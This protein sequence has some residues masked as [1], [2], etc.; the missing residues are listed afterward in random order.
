MKTQMQTGPLWAWMLTLL[1]AGL[2]ADAAVE[3]YKTE[4]EYLNRLAELG[5]GTLSEGFESSAWDI[6]RSP[7]INDHNSPHSVVSQSITWT[8]AAKDIWGTAYS[9]YTHGMT[10]NHNWARSGLWGLFEDHGG[11]GYPTVYRISS[12]IPIYAVGGWFDTN[13][14]YQSVGFL[15]ENRTTANDPGYVL[16]GYGAMYPA[17]VPAIGGHAFVGVVDPAGFTS[18]IVTTTLQVNEEGVLEGGNFVFGS[19]DFTIGVIPEPATMAML[20]V[21]VCATVGRRR[22]GARW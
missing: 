19:D 6:A 7:N 9:Y 12:A 15:F 14:D 17:D 21:T 13:P 2:S 16:P 5:L 1:F 20:A 11:D 10:T 8:A 22:R 4:A 3:R 18:V